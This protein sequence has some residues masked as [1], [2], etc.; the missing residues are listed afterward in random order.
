MAKITVYNQKGEKIDDVDFDE[1]VFDIEPNIHVMHQVVRSQLAARRQGTHQTKTRGQVR[2]GGRKPY[3]QKGT[4]RARQGS[5]RAPQ[6]RGGGTVFG[7]HPR[8]Y[9][10]KVPRKVVK[11][12]MRSALSAKLADDE[13]RVVDSLDFE[14]PRTKEAI[15]FLEA[16]ELDGRITLVIGEDDRNTYLSFRNIPGMRVISMRESNTYDFID[17]KTLVFTLSAIK[18]IEEVLAK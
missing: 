6:W 9:A 10:F 4:G 1:S 5:I 16:M 11:L 13:L 12:A 14:K 2:G 15:S 7:P 3:R 18:Y 17:N 8:S